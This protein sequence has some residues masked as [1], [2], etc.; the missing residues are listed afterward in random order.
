MCFTLG[1][2]ANSAVD[3][4]ANAMMDVTACCGPQRRLVPDDFGRHSVLWP[5]TASK[6]AR[7]GSCRWPFIR[8]KAESCQPTRPQRE[9]HPTCL[10]LLHPTPECAI[11]SSRT[12]HDRSIRPRAPTRRTPMGTREPSADH[13]STG[14]CRTGG[15]GGRMARHRL[16]LPGPHRG[17]GL[18]SAPAATS[19]TPRRRTM[20]AANVIRRQVYL[21][22]CARL[23]AALASPAPPAA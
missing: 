5:H 14:C 20:P 12:T 23:L 17:G 1:A 13:N 15:G 2:K 18:T 8:A 10:P 3:A 9:T 16:H 4:T 19:S 22:G 7:P 6:L 11:L 21:S